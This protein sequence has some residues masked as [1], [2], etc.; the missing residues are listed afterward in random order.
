MVLRGT[1]EISQFVALG[2]GLDERSEDLSSVSCS[3]FASKSYAPVFENA[4]RS[5]MQNSRIINYYLL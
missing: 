1:M 5:G 3:V 2:W 4:M